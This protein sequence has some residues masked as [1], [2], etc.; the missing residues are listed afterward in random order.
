MKAVIDIGTNTFHLLI[1]EI[2][3]GATK[4]IFKQTIAVKLGE[5]GGISRGEIIPAAYQRGL[6]AMKVFSKEIAA[7]KITHVKATATA[8]VRDA[9]NGPAFINDVYQLTQIRIDI[10]DGLQEAIYIYQGAKA[11][12]I[13]TDK[14]VLLM[15][16]GG[17]SVEFI[18]CNQEQ[19]FWKNSFRLGAARLLSDFYNDPLSDKDLNLL[20]AHFERSLSTLSEAIKEHHPEVLIGTAGAFDSFRDIIQAKSGQIN[21]PVIFDLEQ[22]GF[23][24]LLSEIIHSTHEERVKIKG[25]I[26]LRTDMILMASV[27]TKFV[28]L[29]S[30]IDQVK[31]CSYSLKEGLLYLT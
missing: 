27:L 31:A 13:L 3:D 7:R 18:I 16:I 15:D 30:R 14:K 24:K 5:G 2:K 26:P 17:G 25:L 23:S 10:I 19:I 28:L 4:I 22:P 20:N 9:K 8:A 12:G 1:G 21:E 11:S 6:D 29:T